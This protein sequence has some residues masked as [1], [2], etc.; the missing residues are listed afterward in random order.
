M[1][2]TYISMMGIYE[3]ETLVCHEPTYWLIC[4]VT[5]AACWTN[6]ITMTM[7]HHH[8]LLHLKHSVSITE[9]FNVNVL[10]SL[11]Q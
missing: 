5:M 9:C 6:F 8:R 4:D 11:K 10:M 3:E 7:T 1:R 2:S